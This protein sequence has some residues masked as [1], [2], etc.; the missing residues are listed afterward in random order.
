LVNGWNVSR[1][2]I[3]S[4]GTDYYSR[5]TVAFFGLGANLKEDAIYPSCF[6]DKDGNQLNGANK[7]VLRFD[8][9]RTPPANAF[10]SLTLYDP[11]GY[12]VDNPINR[13]TLGDRSKLK[14]NPDGSVNI[15]IQK[16]NPGNDK[17]SNWL[18]TPDGDFN[19]I[20]RVYWPKEEMLNKNW[21]PSAVIKTN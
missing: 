15:Y 20:M 19:L 6:F 8:K 18:P 10:W 2:V 17:A 21:E 7:Y 1:K 16:D 12:F 11:Q 4:Y 14:V 9:G 3:G 13:Y 5:G